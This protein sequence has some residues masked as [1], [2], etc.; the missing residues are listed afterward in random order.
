[1]TDLIIGLACLLYGAGVLVYKFYFG[2]LET[3]MTVSGIVSLLGG[4]YIAIPY[5]LKVFKNVKLPS[6][7]SVNPFKKREEEMEFDLS[8]KELADIQALSYLKDRAV[9]LK[10]EQ[11]M[12]LI[13][14]LNTLLFSSQVAAE[15][16]EGDKQDAEK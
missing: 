14:E 9:E 15:K 11:A 10:S 6:V 12:K 4:C 5:L 1:M 7:P 3:R 13:V 2:E 16:E 8:E